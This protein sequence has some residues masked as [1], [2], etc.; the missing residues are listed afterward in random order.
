MVHR[1]LQTGWGN[2]Q[3]K[4]SSK[5][6]RPILQPSGEAPELPQGLSD[7]PDDTLMELYRD[8]VVWTGYAGWLVAEAEIDNRQAER[9]LKRCEDKYTV[10]FKTEK[11]VS[12]I[13][14]RVAS[15]PEFQELEDVV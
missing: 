14:A 6:L 4:L 9:K 3:E 12:A 2:P 13:K 15:E 8:L 1:P 5:G 7:L 10:Q 11:T